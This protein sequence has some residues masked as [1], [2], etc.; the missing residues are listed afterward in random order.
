MTQK[1]ISEIRQRVERYIAEGRLRDAIRLV[2]NTAESSMRWEISDRAARAEQN[3]AYMLQYLTGGANDPGRDDFYTSV[4]AETYAC[5]DTLDRRLLAQERSTL[6]FSTV[7]T[8]ELQTGSFAAS[9]AQYR[10][11]AKNNDNIRVEQSLTDL[12]Y[13]IWTA[14][15]LPVEDASELTLLALDPESSPGLKHIIISALTLGLLEYNDTTRIDALADIYLTGSTAIPVTDKEKVLNYQVTVMALVGLLLGL[16]RH[17]NRLTPKSTLRKLESLSA[18]PTWRN[19]LRTVFLEIIRTRNTERVNRT[20]QEEII[21]GMMKLKPEII[22]GIEGGV[23][24]PENLEENPE[25]ED[26]MRKS[27]LSDRIR[28]LSEMQQQ[29]A[30]VFMS[31]FAHLKSFPFFRDMPNWFLPFIRKHPSVTATK[32]PEKLIEFIADVPFLCAGDKYSFVFSL[33]MVPEEQRKLM[34]SQLETQTGQSL[35]EMK[36]DLFSGTHQDL[37]QRA[38]SGYLRSLYRFYHLFRRKGEFYN[39][40]DEGLNLLDVPGLEKEF[41]DPEMLRVIAELFFNLRYWADAARTFERLDNISDP[42]GQVYQK[43]GYCYHRIG[44]YNRA[45]NFY[46]QAE[47]FAPDSPWLLQRIAA[48]YNSNGQLPQAATYYGK[49]ETLHPEN[50]EAVLQLGYIFLKQGLY[51][52]ALKQFFK[53]QY[54]DP[55]GDKA[56]RP[57]AWTLFLSGRLDESR[58]YY[59]KIKENNPTASDFINMGHLEMASGKYKDA[60]DYYGNALKLVGNTE[61]IISLIKRDQPQ[62]TETGVDPRTV[63]MVIDALLYTADR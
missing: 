51:E 53:V 42:D 57:L 45:L 28:E 20:M 17:R 47:I 52:K 56:L 55:T 18:V 14:Y 30:D 36:S 39:P 12:F 11:A 21:P 25:W 60:V 35:E 62:L 4:I 63:S 3:Y 29:G 58:Q 6:Y 15:P 22:K 26:L 13:R 23:I 10:T 40:F 24:D 7:R 41:D 38:A 19:D 33:G 61:E 1:E 27:G 31:T 2:R 9:L 48:A 54:L 5:L 34:L 16:Y 43:L 44:N 32:L 59:S 37:F 46:L 49:L 50:V 8:L